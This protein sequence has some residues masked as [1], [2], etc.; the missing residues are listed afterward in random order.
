VYDFVKQMPDVEEVYVFAHLGG[1]ERLVALPMP[2]LRVLQL[3][4]GFSYPLERLAKNPSLTRLT[5]LL[6]HPHAIERGSSPYIQL[7]ELRAVCRSPHLTG[8]THLRLRLTDFGDKGVEEIVKSGILRRLKVLDLRHGAITD[9]GAELLADCPDLKN[10][11]RLDLSRNG[12]TAA[13]KRLLTETGVPADLSFQHL[14]VGDQDAY[15]DTP[16][17]LFEGDY[18]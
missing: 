15:G 17:Y 14:E 8:L 16:R 4:H 3:Y 5:H 12:L 13:G 9:K 1:A 2:R 10:L 11:A 18:E 7:R 6:C